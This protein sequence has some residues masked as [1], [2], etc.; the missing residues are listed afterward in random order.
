[1]VDGTG[2]EPL[3]FISH[4]HADGP[5]A[6][7]LA[8]FIRN[9]TA[10]KVRVHLSSSPNFDGPRLGRPLGEELRRALATA[11]TVILVFTSET[12]DWSYCMWECGVA[13]DPTDSRPTSVVVM[14]C[15]PD[16]P[17]PYG[18]QLRVDVNDVGSLQTFVKA[19]LTTTD[20]FPHRK[21]PLTGFAPEGREVREF[22]A[23]LQRDIAAV[24]PGDWRKEKRRP[25]CP[26]LRVH[27]PDEAARELRS[28]CATALTAARCREIVA[29]AGQIVGH[30][31]AQSLFGM[32]LPTGTTLGQVLADWQDDYDPGAEPRW[33][34]ALVEQIESA[35]AGKLRAVKWAPYR[36]E[37]GRSDVPFVSSWRTV[38]RGFEF[39]VY[40]V[41]FSPRPVPV[42]DK[43]I[44]RDQMYA[45]DAA[46]EPFSDVLLLDLVRE[47]RRHEVTRLP[48]LRDGAPLAIIHRATID[49]FLV[50]S[51][52][53]GRTGE[54]TLDDLLASCGDLGRSFVEV[55]TQ[56]T[57]EEATTAMEAHRPCQ[58][59]YVTRA[60][61]VVG[62][63]PNVL[64]IPQ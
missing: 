17:K 29:S 36:S 15:T 57:I 3:V 20:L 27:L 19:L 35:L 63:L 60:G 13:T 43:M 33:F 46:Y 28:S 55:S 30:L 4:R 34:D 32:I 47:M 2:D 44:P 26:Y 61:R 16:E 6:E 39:D 48:L 24:L 42:G 40:F 59:V 21:A 64:L 5:I 9:R 41:P 58:D 10:G 38:A 49:A 12:Q 51:F 50:S 52:D 1:M 31:D 56:A 45:K 37:T 53:D 8:R 62:W 14:Q 25:T 18:D 23:E 54:L 7:T 11:E 22:A